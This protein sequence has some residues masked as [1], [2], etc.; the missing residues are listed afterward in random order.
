MKG[1]SDPETGLVYPTKRTATRE[2]H[3]ASNCTTTCFN[4]CESTDISCRQQD[5]ALR[6]VRFLYMMRWP[7]S[8]HRIGSLDLI[9]FFT[10]QS[11][12]AVSNPATALFG[13]DFITYLHTNILFLP[14]VGRFHT[15]G[16]LLLLHNYCNL[17]AA[18]SSWWSQERFCVALFV[19]CG[20]WICSGARFLKHLNCQKTGGH[21]SNTLRSFFFSNVRLSNSDFTRS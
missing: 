17:L 7:H 9:S 14:L 11:P 15:K 12:I 4:N 10:P 16:P 2:G 13:I 18:R 19:N 3:R 20:T 8:L 6:F 5:N 1:Y 21:P